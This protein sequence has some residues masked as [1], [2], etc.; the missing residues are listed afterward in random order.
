MPPHIPNAPAEPLPAGYLRTLLARVFPGQRADCHVSPLPGDASDRR[1]YRPRLLHS[2]DARLGPCQ[3]DL[4]SLLY[5]AYVELPADLRQELLAYYLGQKA[6]TDGPPLDPAAFGQVFAYTCLRRHLKAL[7]TFAFQTVS[8]HTRRYVA[9]MP[10]T[11]GYLRD[12]LA[13]HPEL[14]PLRDLLEAYLF[15]AAPAALRAAETHT[16]DRSPPR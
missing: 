4:A 3:Y 15:A 1:Y 14:R 8:R 9:A 5:D 13:R 7:G 16:P 11:L 12:N 10:P 6:A 2:Q